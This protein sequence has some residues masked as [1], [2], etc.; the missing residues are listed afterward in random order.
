M[1]DL[2]RSVG[3]AV[4]ALVATAVGKSRP[5]TPVV[6]AAN[7]GGGG[8]MM[9]MASP[10][11]PLSP[12]LMALTQSH[13][14]PVSPGGNIAPATPTATA[15]ATAGAASNADALYD[16]AFAVLN[17]SKLVLD[18]PALQLFLDNGYDLHFI[19][20][21]GCLAHFSHLT[22]RPLGLFSLVPTSPLCRYIRENMDDWDEDV[23]A[24]ISAYL[25]PGGKM[26]FE[27][28]WK[29]ARACT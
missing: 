20:P 26:T 23:I 22:S 25:K 5:T 7:A 19:V 11:S 16:A 3:E 28:K 14:T 12:S 6:P 24:T 27:K 2:L 4:H 9:M 13:D 17:N 18:M 29:A 15:T 8:M 10:G 21:I 1:F